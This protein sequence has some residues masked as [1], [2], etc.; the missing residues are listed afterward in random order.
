[1]S[2]LAYHALTSTKTK[3]VLGRDIKY[4]NEPTL[5]VRNGEETTTIVFNELSLNLVLDSKKIQMSRTVR[6]KFNS[7]M[8]VKGRKKRAN[9]K[10]G[11]VDGWKKSA[12]ITYKHHCD[13]YSIYIIL[14]DTQIIYSHVYPK[15]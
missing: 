8:T 14:N 3:V 12:F 15:V 1:M 6:T 4:V 13:S 2:Q 10:F 9:V 7:I 5:I 11:Y